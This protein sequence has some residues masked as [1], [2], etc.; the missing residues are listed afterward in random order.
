MTAED[1]GFAKSFNMGY[2]TF[3][4]PLPLSRPNPIL[5]GRGEL[6]MLLGV[7]GI[8]GMVVCSRRSQ[9][10]S[11]RSAVKTTNRYAELKVPEQYRRL[12]KWTA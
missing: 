5:G 7:F 3:S 2:E 10:E 9:E 4:R 1:F 8:V 6:F 11:L 12:S